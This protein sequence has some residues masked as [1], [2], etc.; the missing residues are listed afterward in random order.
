MPNL[1]IIITAIDEATAT[2]RNIGKEIAAAD[3]GTGAYR[4]KTI[5]ERNAA[6][7][8]QYELWQDNIASQKRYQEMSDFIYGKTLK[9]SRGFRNMATEIELADQKMQGIRNSMQMIDSGQYGNIPYAGR[10]G[11]SNAKRA[12]ALEDLSKQYTET[13]K[14]AK[15][16]RAI[17]QQ[18]YPEEKEDKQISGFDKLYV[19]LGKIARAIFILRT[20]SRAATQ[21]FNFTEHGAQIY[22]LAEASEKTAEFYGLNMNKIME[23]TRNASMGTVSDFDLMQSSAQGMMFGVRGSEEQF[24]ALME[25]AAMRAR[26][27]GVT[28]TKAFSDI[29]RGIGRL[30]PLILDN[31]GIMISA[32]QTYEDYARS[33]GKSASGLTAFEKRQALLYRVIEE[34]QIML[35]A[36]GGLS[37]DRQSAIEYV[38]ANYQNLL[39]EAAEVSSG[40]LSRMGYRQKIFELESKL[41]GSGTSFEELGAARQR[42]GV[43]AST[44]FNP[45][46][47]VFGLRSGTAWLSTKKM[48]AYANE[49]LKIQRLEEKIRFEADKKYKMSR[50]KDLEMRE[51]LW[52]L[53]GYTK[54]EE[55]GQEMI[56]RQRESDEAF[57]EVR[58]NREAARITSEKTAY[59]IAV[60]HELTNA[61]NELAEALEYANK[62]GKKE[63]GELT[64]AAY[65][66]HEESIESF[67]M[68]LMEASGASYDF[69][70]QFGVALG[71][72]DEKALAAHAAFKILM[73]GLKPENYGTA[74]KAGTIITEMLKDPEKTAQDIENYLK[75]V[76]PKG[77]EGEFSGIKIPLEFAE[78]EEAANLIAQLTADE[79][80]TIW[81]NYRVGVLS[82]RGLGYGGSANIYE[83]QMQ[84]GGYAFRNNPYLVGEAGPELFIPNQ[85]GRV[86]SADRTKNI[87]A[88]SGTYHF[89]NKVTFV[90]EGGEVNMGKLMKQ[91]GV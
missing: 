1:S 57:A 36:Q 53:G 40:A 20:I 82:K 87:S 7:D 50:A 69:M 30:S 60:T 49:L 16:L 58:A 18:M 48:E 89:Y 12:K 66:K 45:L 76:F 62:K 9:S 77:A 28:T 83:H 56:D 23:S 84:H 59:E 61:Y 29:M 72:V 51:R 8:T 52:A 22:R 71:Q 55:I 79:S 86:L 90:V 31:L 63:S 13:E 24:G 2:I 6:L 46:D 32:K 68:T 25:V 47:S 73:Q 14:R 3:K 78:T 34:N 88:G 75:T 15:D 26:S 44:S 54:P 65:A 5:D 19:T 74:V 37:F 80:K 38:K 10:V 67:A 70:L 42:A 41:F 81:V 64:T 35:D 27:M 11:K 33:V 39:N 43:S 91:L 85:S 21:A 4:S 17:Q